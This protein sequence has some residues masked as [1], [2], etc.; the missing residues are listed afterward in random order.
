MS[1]RKIKRE[2]YSFLIGL[3]ILGNEPIFECMLK[4]ICFFN[5]WWVCYVTRMYPFFF[6]FESSVLPL[7]GRN[8]GE[9]NCGGR[10]DCGIK[11]CEFWLNSQSFLP[12]FTARGSNSQSFLSQFVEKIYNLQSFL[13]QC[14]EKHKFVDVMYEL[15]KANIIFLHFLCHQT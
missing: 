10:K 7:K 6:L 13:P 4:D 12:Q 1:N 11:D 5:A 14:P 8:Y 2:I 15:L 3:R 9:R